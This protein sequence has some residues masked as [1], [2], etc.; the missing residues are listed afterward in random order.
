MRDHAETFLD[1]DAPT[2]SRLRELT[3]RHLTYGRSGK[4]QLNIC[5]HSKTATPRGGAP[6]DAARG[7]SYFY[8]AIPGVA[9]PTD[10]FMMPY[11][12]M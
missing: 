1:F 4:L 12:S 10:A 9:T 3:L 5:G 6:T 11:A 2:S 7:G 8:C